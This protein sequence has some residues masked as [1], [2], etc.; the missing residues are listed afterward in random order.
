MYNFDQPIDRRHTNSVK[1]DECSNPDVLPLW[2]ADMDF[3]TAP[4]VQEAIVR[5]A[6]HGCYGYTIVPDAYYAAICDWFATRHQWNIDPQ[7]IL[8]TIGVIPAIAAVLK[9]QCQVGDIVVILTPVYNMFFNLVRNAG[10]QVLEVPVLG[11]LDKADNTWRY[12]IDWEQLESALA[13][14]KTTTLL[15]CNPHNPIG[16]IWSEE[17]LLRVAQL[18][19][20]HHVTLISDEIHNEITAPNRLY[21]PLARV[22]EGCRAKDPRLA[23]L[24]YVVCLSP[25]KSFNIA[26]LQNAFLVCPDDEM[27]R[28]IDRAINLNETCD[29][30]PFGVEAVIAAYTEGGEWLDELRSYIYDNYLLARKELA[31]PCADLQGTY[32]LWV[33]CRS[34]CQRWGIDS[35]ELARRLLID[36]KVWFSVGAD[37]GRAGEGFLRINLACTHATLQ[38]ALR[39]FNEYIAQH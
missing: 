20:Q 39:R 24:R 1:W 8:Y 14:E 5:R 35:H 31:L 9:A 28:R 7:H 38:E 25:S 12:D 17:E 6:T 15:F 26:G 11:E 3:T 36:A 30:N 21:H 29:V 13:Q 10:C 27:R 34:V 2:V 23:D 16:R 18:C 4:C 22:V 19:A 37:Y 33:D 32:L